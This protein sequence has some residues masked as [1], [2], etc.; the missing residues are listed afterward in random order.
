MGKVTLRPYQE[1]IL[2]EVSNLASFGLFMGTGTGKT[3]TSL[4]RTN[5]NPTKRLLIV[6]PKSV[7][8]Q[9]EYVIETYFN[10]F[11]ILKYK[12]Y[13]STEKIKDFVLDNISDTHN[14]LVINYD[15]LAR[16]DNLVDLIDD[17]WTVILDESH[18][19]K[20]A[21][22][23]RYKDNSGDTKSHKEMQ[24][25]T[26]IALKIGVKT[27][28]KIILTATPT[29][30]NYGGY[31]DYFSQL[32]FLGYIDYSLSEYRKRFCI[33]DDIVVRG[34]PYPVK[35]IVGY[36]NTDELDEILYACCRSYKA[37]FGDFEPEHINVFFDKPKS[38]AHTHTHHK[39]K[40]IIMS[41]ISRTRIA[42]K[43]L[44]TGRIYGRGFFDDT[45][46]YDDN[47][48]KEDWLIEF[49]EDTDETLAIYYNYDVE[50]ARLEEIMKK[51]N[52]RY[53]VINGDT[54]D[55]FKE[56]N[57]KD[58]DVM[59]G[60]YQTASEALDGLQ[61]KSHIAILWAL[62]ESSR[63]YK[64]MLGRI[65]RDGQ[66]RVPIYYYLITKGTVEEMIYKMIQ[67]KVEF[68]E[69]VIDKLLIEEDKSV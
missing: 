28:W 33:T 43:T 67:D 37:N 38:Y 15:R 36:K 49:I 63:L 40:D 51:L 42:L 35:S 44:C 1:K 47:T 69:E 53:V 11:N 60:Q 4:V 65:N 17:N 24:K 6:C 46:F 13:W 52:K 25:T 66:A 3:I 58:F 10:R 16:F 68:S 22:I 2:N 18:R 64:Q 56:I 12:R 50:L 19:I 62:P 5:E 23:K 45:Y 21:S 55:A 39:Y 61:F 41:N 14:T 26:S 27:P 48:I 57:E 34:L 59:L 30:G 20:D 31:I 9:W 8:S 29:Q 7:I 32:K 54:R